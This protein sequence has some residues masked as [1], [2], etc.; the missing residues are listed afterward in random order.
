MFPLWNG[1]EMEAQE[2]IQ[3]TKCDA[4]SKIGVV[5]QNGLRFCRG[6]GRI[7][8]GVMSMDEVRQIAKQELHHLPYRTHVIFGEHDKD[9]REVLTPIVIGNAAGMCG[10]A[11]VIVLRRDLAPEQLLSSFYHEIGHIRYYNSAFSR[12]DFDGLNLDM[13]ENEYNAFHYGISRLFEEGRMLLVHSQM[14]RTAYDLKHPKFPPHHRAALLKLM[15][16]SSWLKWER[17]LGVSF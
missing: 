15:Q 12:S 2:S 6:C 9:Y 11:Q 16:S 5:D 14:E 1:R 10:F 7:N 3:M 17:S 8:D 13:V 4:C